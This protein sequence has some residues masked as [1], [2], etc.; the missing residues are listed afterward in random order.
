MK[1][2]FLFLHPEINSEFVHSTQ[3]PQ[4]ASSS[5]FSPGEIPE[6]KKYAQ[7]HVQVILGNRGNLHVLRRDERQRYA[8]GPRY[9]LEM[10]GWENRE[11][12]S[13]EKWYTLHGTVNLLYD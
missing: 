4:A 7:G 1:E 3:R 12:G 13:I 8:K 10:D 2:R 5:R 11:R 6:P 9:S